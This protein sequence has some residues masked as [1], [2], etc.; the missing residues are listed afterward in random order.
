MFYKEYIIGGELY[1]AGNHKYLEKVKTKSGKWRYIYTRSNAGVQK[2]EN[3]DQALLDKKNKDK[4]DL[5]KKVLNK[6]TLLKYKKENVR[7][8]KDHLKGK[9]F[10]NTK[11]FLKKSNSVSNKETAVEDEE[12]KNTKV[13]SGTKTGKS[14]SSSSKSRGKKGRSS[15]S[16]KGASSKGKASSSSSSASASS[17]VSQEE[18]QREQEEREIRSELTYK[19]KKI[20][21][22]KYKDEDLEKMELKELNDLWEKIEDEDT[23][24]EKVLKK[25]Q[26]K[27]LKGL[28]ENI[29]LNKGKRERVKK[30]LDDYI[31]RNS[32]KII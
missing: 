5:T 28:S 27:T 22:N 16:S 17:K 19:I 14:G 24:D 2:A 29:K 32:N 21:G 8:I 23:K 7:S 20:T 12:L 15:S 18:K 4:I 13:V 1:H 11:N 26:K 3:V 6:N 30:M 31:Y 9:K 25:R 10:S